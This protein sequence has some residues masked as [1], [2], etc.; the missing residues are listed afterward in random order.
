L[1]WLVEAAVGIL[2][3]VEAVLVVIG[4]AQRKEL[5]LVKPTQLQ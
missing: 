4:Q 5:F 2:G 3:V 1:W